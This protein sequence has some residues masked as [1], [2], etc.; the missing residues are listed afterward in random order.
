MCREI[1]RQYWKHVVRNLNVRPDSSLWHSRDN[2]VLLGSCESKQG[3]GG[4]LGHGGMWKMP[5]IQSFSWGNNITWS[6][7]GTKIRHPLWPICWTGQQHATLYDQY[8]ESGNYI[9]SIFIREQNPPPPFYQY[10]ERANN[11]N[12]I[13]MRD[14]NLPPPQN[15]ILIGEIT[16]TLS[17]WGIKISHPFWTIGWLRD[18]NSGQTSRLQR[19]C[20]SWTTHDLVRSWSVV[21]W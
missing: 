12:F 18:I 8:V 7:W 3:Q 19:T 21:G 4:K 1:V 17:S 10:A 9:N 6:S 16:S 13:F 15:N 5:W 2:S 14:Q 11:I 20:F